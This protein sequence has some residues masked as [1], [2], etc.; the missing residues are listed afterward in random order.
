MRV[1]GIPLRAA[2]LQLFDPLGL[3]FEVRPSGVFVT[4]KAASP[5]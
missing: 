5:E 2:L 4:A 1:K 3:A